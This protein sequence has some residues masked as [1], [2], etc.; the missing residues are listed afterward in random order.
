MQTLSVEAIRDFQVCELY[1][2]Y[3]HKEDLGEV[4]N[5]EELSNIRF[6]NCLK[7]VASFFFYKKQ[8]ENTPSYTAILNRWEKLWF[9][10]GITAYDMAVEQR[11]ITRPNMASL[12]VVAAAALEKFHDF[13][14]ED[15]FVPVTVDEEYLVPIDRKHTLAGSFDLVL[16]KGDTYRVIKWHGRRTRLKADRSLLDFA[17]LKYAFEYRAEGDRKIEYYIY[18]LASTNKHFIQMDQPTRADVEALLYWGRQAA[19]KE[20]CVPRRGYTAYCRGCAYDESC[21]SW[22]EWAKGS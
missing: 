5:A 14:C 18:D 3:K 11:S 10:K 12:S 22:N 19:N 21:A 16:K 8:A 4:I 17:A 2:E 15:D 20:L 9:P 6:E 7:K 1:Y 13:F